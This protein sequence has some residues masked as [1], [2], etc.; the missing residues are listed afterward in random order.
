MQQV[1]ARMEHSVLAPSTGTDAGATRRAVAS[2]F[3][4]M[5]ATSNTRAE[6]YSTTACTDASATRRAVQSVFNKMRPTTQTSAAYATVASTDVL[7][8]RIAVEDTFQQMSNAKTTPARV[9]QHLTMTLEDLLA[10]DDVASTHR[11][12]ERQ[13]ESV[14]AIFDQM[15]GTQVDSSETPSPRRVPQYL[16]MTLEELLAT[17]NVLS[18][19]RLV[20]RGVS[21]RA[22]DLPPPKKRESVDEIFGLIHDGDLLADSGW[23]R[24]KIP[25]HLTMTLEEL[26]ATEKISATHRLV[27]RPTAVPATAK[28]ASAASTKGTTEDTTRPH[29]AEVGQVFRIMETA[30]QQTLEIITKE[31][32]I[33]AQSWSDTAPRLRA[34]RATRATSA[35]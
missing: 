9:P 6:T 29:A 24:Q 30:D 19:S 11:L 31:A 33:E 12:V 32:E 15:N 18:T 3:N 4:R 25:Q 22:T 26:V 35:A 17:D 34:T 16:T 5:Q 27:E 10:T 2:V 20:E 21:A 14:N 23:R 7:S 28:N 1:F 13:P 8:T